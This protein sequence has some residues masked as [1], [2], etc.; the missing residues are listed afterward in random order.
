[1][2]SSQAGH[3]GP[4]KRWRAVGPGPASPTAARRIHILAA[5]ALVLVTVA[6]SP[7]RAEERCP[8]SA[9]PP[10]RVAAVDRFGDL[11]LADG[12][13][14][15]LAALSAPDDATNEARRAEALREAA[16]GRDVVLARAGAARDRYGRIAALA[17][18]EGRET[19]PATLQAV[20][21]REGLALAQPEAGFLGCMGELL[22][23]EAPARAARRGLWAELPVAARDEARASA[24]EGRFTILAGR[25]LSVG[26]GRSVDYL[27]FGP[28]W[29]QDS[30]VRLE[31]P[32]RAALERAGVPLESLRGR[33]LAVR[34][35]VVE[36][37]GPAIDVRWIEQLELLDAPW[38]DEGRRKQSE[39]AGEDGGAGEGMAAAARAAGGH[40]CAV[41]RAV[42]LRRPAGAAHHRGQGD[43]GGR[44][45]GRR[46]DDAGAA[47]GARAP[48]R[49]LWRRL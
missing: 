49:L 31:K 45:F 46:H 20:L 48:R 8:A 4:D 29:R 34:G 26:N 37:G 24:R 17:R 39:D 47:Q 42:G 22:A 23:M 28:V 41:A 9:D 33:R 16:L 1:M 6:P 3:A 11:V 5:V 36:A 32:V 15:R 21:L 7:S 43:A 12:A 13:T 44:A 27:N 2:I 18:I 30:T 40:A 38:W 14:I 25:V 10:V 35:V 19:E